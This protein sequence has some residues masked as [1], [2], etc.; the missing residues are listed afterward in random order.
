LAALQLIE[1][2]PTAI[3][4]VLTDVIM[5]HMGGAELAR[6][7]AKLA[8][9]LPVVFMTGYTNEP[10]SGEFQGRPP[11]VLAKPFS[12]A[13]LHRTLKGVFGEDHFA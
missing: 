1:N 8:P 12:A 4:L 11:V 6:R 5:P 9:K 2:A 10:I 13:D 7:L 3:N